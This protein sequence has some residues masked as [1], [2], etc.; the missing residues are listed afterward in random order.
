MNRRDGAWGVLGRCY[1][2]R[3]SSLRLD[4]ATGLVS[5]T[6]VEEVRYSPDR[7]FLQ[8][9]P[10]GFCVRLARPPLSALDP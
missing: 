10:F 4:R 5:A 8:E 6:R 2:R 7:A 1:L 3:S 9:T